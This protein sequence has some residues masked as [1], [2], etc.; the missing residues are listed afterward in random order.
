VEVLQFITHY[1]LGSSEIISVEEITGNFL[2]VA[3]HFLLWSGSKLS[4]SRRANEVQWLP[5]TV[6]WHYG[7]PL[8][9][10]ITS[11]ELQM[12]ET[13]QVLCKEHCNC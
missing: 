11:F 7:C 1:D 4:Y 8:R 12:A 2:N 6:M 10:M 9:H 3:M 13:V 5:F